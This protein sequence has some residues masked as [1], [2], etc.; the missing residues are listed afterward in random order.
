M[1][2]SEDSNNPS[3]PTNVPASRAAP[4]DTP[5][6]VPKRVSG[7][8]SMPSEQSEPPASDFG[9]RPRDRRSGAGQAIEKLATM[10]LA[11]L[12]PPQ[13]N[14]NMLSSLKPHFQRRLQDLHNERAQ[15]A[16]EV[17]R[18]HLSEDSMLSQVL[19]WLAVGEREGT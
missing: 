10:P 14:L 11:V 9:L 19:Q 6:D 17:S 16:G 4:A 12:L 3:D 7:A 18:E 13:G 15:L 5:S 1:A 2:N 8:L